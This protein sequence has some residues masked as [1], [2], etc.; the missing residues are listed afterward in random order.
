MNSSG[1]D[2]LESPS[3]DVTEIVLSESGEPPCSVSSTVAVQKLMSQ[4]ENSMF[5]KRPGSCEFLPQTHLPPRV[6]Q[7]T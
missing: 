1:K 4:E 3:P 5:E 7:P 6:G 2:T